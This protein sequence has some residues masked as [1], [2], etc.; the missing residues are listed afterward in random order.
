MD[1]V[2]ILDWLDDPRVTCRNVDRNLS[3]FVQP[4]KI[5]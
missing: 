3:A 4:I 1:F 5:I 2:D